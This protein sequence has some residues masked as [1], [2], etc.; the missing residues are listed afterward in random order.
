[1]G[2]FAFPLCDTTILTFQLANFHTFS[3][4]GLHGGDGQTPLLPLPHSPPLPRR[5]WGK[6]RRLLNLAIHWMI[7]SL[8]FDFNARVAPITPPITFIV[9][10]VTEGKRPWQ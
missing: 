10:S 9:T 2:S 6:E 1:M 7:T 4:A 8:M 3:A 5:D